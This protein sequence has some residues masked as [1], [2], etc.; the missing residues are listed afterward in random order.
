MTTCDVKN[1]TL[2]L[3]SRDLR[4]LWDVTLFRQTARGETRH[5]EC[6]CRARRGRHVNR[7]MMSGQINS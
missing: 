4:D 5:G 1:V 2:L 7:S 6:H 3:L